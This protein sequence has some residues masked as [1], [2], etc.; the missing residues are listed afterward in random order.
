VR[1]PEIRRAVPDDAP[2]LTE[3]AHAA[4]RHWGY[5]EELIE[6]WVDDLTVTERFFE[7]HPVHCAVDGSDI[8]GFYALSNDGSTFEL[9]HMWVDPVRIG[10]GVGRALFEHAVRAV[11]T[12]GGAVLR[13]GSDP[14]AV[15]F[16]EAMG[17]RLVG[18]VPSK[19]QGRSLP[20]LELVIG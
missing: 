8:L 7:S 14:N 13:I 16:Y 3:V 15:G 20:L 2:R 12:L 5:D 17:A 4:K 19:P 18:E 6:L 1:S 9:E 11:Q 10:T